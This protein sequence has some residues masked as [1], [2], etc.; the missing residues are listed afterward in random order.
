MS[1]YSEEFEG[2]DNEIIKNDD[3][4]YSS[5]LSQKSLSSETHQEKYQKNLQV[6]REEIKA[7]EIE[8]LQNLETIESGETLEVLD[9]SSED[10]MIYIKKQQAAIRK[11]LQHKPRSYSRPNPGKTKEILIPAEKPSKNSSFHSNYKKGLYRNKES[12]N[13]ENAMFYAKPKLII[14]AMPDIKNLK[15]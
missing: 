2:S 9:D 15:A 7:L 14:S 11:K 12:V 6:L 1:N 10:D 4:V 8:Q 3:E 5:D 13:N